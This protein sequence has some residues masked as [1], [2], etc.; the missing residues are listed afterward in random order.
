ML[1]RSTLIRNQLDPNKESLIYTD[2]SNFAICVVLIQE[3]NLIICTSKALNKSQK[4]WA[5]IEK[6]MLAISFSCKKLRQY[7]LGHKFMVFTVHKPLL[8][9]FKHVERV[10]NQRLLTLVLTT[11]EFNFEIKYVQGSKN[12]IADFGSRHI[13][14]TDYSNDSSSDD[15]LIL[16]FLNSESLFNIPDY[17]AQSLTTED[18]DEQIGRA[19][20]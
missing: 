12:I 6:E 1:F 3:G 18:H 15:D 9:I 13:P 14:A 20:V 5:T 7:L 8:G 10:E 16:N 19:H 11:S 2:A 4:K 17:N